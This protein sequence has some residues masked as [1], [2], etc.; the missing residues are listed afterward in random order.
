MCDR[1]TQTL[2]YLI[3]LTRHTDDHSSF[4]KG[5][6]PDPARTNEGLGQASA[7]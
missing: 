3:R 5:G 7:L 1:S 6:S 4:E 2:E